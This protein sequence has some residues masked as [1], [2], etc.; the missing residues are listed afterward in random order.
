MCVETNSKG[1]IRMRFPLISTFT[2]CTLFAGA[3]APLGAGTPASGTSKPTGA[4]QGPCDQ[5]TQAC[6][7][8]GFVLG[9]VK[10]G[11]GLVI[12][13]IRPIMNGVAQPA[14]AKIPLPQVPSGTV[15]ACKT[16]H[17]DFG[18]PKHN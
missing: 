4:K 6:K 3:V 8:A 10:E 11:N 9:D 1:S 12:D 16:K 18:E 7:S 17:P 13:C 15:A 2:A 5:I 14:K